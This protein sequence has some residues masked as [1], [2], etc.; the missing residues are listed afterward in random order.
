MKI[1]FTGGGTAGHIF[2]IIAIVKE[3][4]RLHPESRIQFSYIGPKDKFVQAILSQEGVEIKTILTGKI[5][6][7]FS[8]WNA[9]DIFK[10]PI[11]FLQAFFHIFTISPDIIFS[12]GGYGSLPAVIAGSV[13]L[14]P[15]FLHESDIIPGLAN[16]IAS[17]IS[18]EIFTSFPVEKTRYFPAK[19]ML[20]VG[21][22]VRKEIME[23]SAEK[24]KELFKLTGEKKVILVLG[25]SQGS[26][27][28][29]DKILAILGDMLK[30]FEIIHQAGQNNFDQVRSETEAVLEDGQKKY[31]HPFSFLNETELANAFAAADLVVSRAGSGSIFEIA[32]TGK[33][34]ILVP[35]S[36]SAQDHQVANAYAFAETGAAVVLEETNFTPHFLL[37]RIK[38]LFSEQK[39]LKQMI[40][41]A[42]EFAKPN[43]AKVIAEYVHTYLS[44]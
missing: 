40:K 33:P 25:G 4:K 22:P 10:I 7:Y 28:V 15:V 5:R 35:L 41:K 17:K 8:F 30:D 13:F 39:E 36:G 20:F 12:K 24:A 3:L 27:T 42:R 6:R 26:Q 14:T 38:H 31:Y 32:A 29:N 34:S 21:N 18:I 9:V 37:E 11:G 43:S 1:L 19:K 44:Q 16:R 23:G 2:P